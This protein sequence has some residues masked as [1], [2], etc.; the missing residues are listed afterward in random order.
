MR[1]T[2]PA[3]AS[4]PDLK[5]EVF[6][7]RVLHGIGD[8]LL[9]TPQEGMRLIGANQD[10][11]RYVDVDHR[12]RNALRQGLQAFLEAAAFSFAQGGDHIANL[13]EQGAG[14]PLG[15][16]NMILRLGGL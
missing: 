5:P 14:E 12:S 16:E 13:A 15:L 11:G 1:S 7:I 8:R 9:R 6:R 2:A 4:G 3:V 10:A